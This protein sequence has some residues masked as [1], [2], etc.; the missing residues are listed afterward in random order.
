MNTSPD[1]NARRAVFFVN[2]GRLFIAFALLA[3]FGAWV[4]E[5]RPGPL[6]GMTQEHLFNDA[7]TLALIGIAFLLD[8]LLHTKNL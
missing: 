4:T 2:L 5:F 8:S 7:Q 1:K 3:L 6:F